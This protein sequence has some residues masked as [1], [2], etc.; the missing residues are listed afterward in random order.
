VVD[1]SGMRFLAGL[2]SA[3][4]MCVLVC[5]CVGALLHGATGDDVDHSRRRRPRLFRCHRLHHLL[6][7][8]V[9]WADG[10]VIVWAV[11]WPWPREM[12]T[13][14][15]TH[16]RT[17]NLDPTPYPTIHPVVYILYFIYRP[18]GAAPPTRLTQQPP[19]TAAADR[20][21][22]TLSN[23]IYNDNNSILVCYK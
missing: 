13:H 6:R 18:D 22:G 12:N 21:N 2:G 10:D 15:H 5:A 3:A 23:I 9:C 20:V 14:T 7:S 16:T 1:R 17:H 19:S 11:A 4:L 8:L